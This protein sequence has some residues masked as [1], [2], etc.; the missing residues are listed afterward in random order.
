M[1]F[2]SDFVV[3]SRWPGAKL[4]EFIE[5]RLETWMGLEL[6]RDKTREVDLRQEGA[7]L[8][9][10]GYTFRYDRDLRGR[11]HR[12][13]NVFPSKKAVAREREKLREM[14]GPQQCWKPIPH[15]LADVNLHL[16]GWANYFGYGYSSVALRE[17]NGYVRQ[18][19]ARHLRRR[20]QRP[21]RPPDGV[22]GS[23]YFKRMGLCYLKAGLAK[24]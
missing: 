23:E 11:K 10:L 21:F 15:L 8:D 6:N 17:I 2:R 3:L 7:S 20:S 12:Y 4:R 9:F 19:L 24:A 5:E 13:L 1:L 16:R 22:T 18:R 14:T